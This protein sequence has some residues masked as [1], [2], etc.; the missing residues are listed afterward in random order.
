[1]SAQAP[2]TDDPHH[3]HR[4]AKGRVDPRLRR[5][6]AEVGADSVESYTGAGKP[7][8][9]SILLTFEIGRTDNISNFSLPDK[10]VVGSI[11]KSTRGVS[12]TIRYED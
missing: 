6:A 4:A 5:F 10:M 12:I 3:N 1:M 7:R 9:G 11:R 8:A 2:T